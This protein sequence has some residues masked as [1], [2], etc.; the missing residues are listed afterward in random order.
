MLN[1][2]V[3]RKKKVE[4]EIRKVLRNNVS[5]VKLTLE[6]IKDRQKQV[7]FNNLRI[8]LRKKKKKC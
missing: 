7:I 6:T 5:K 2:L 4:N 3:N 1:K 8:N